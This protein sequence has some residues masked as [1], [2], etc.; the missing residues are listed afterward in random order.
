MKDTGSLGKIYY[1]SEVII[2]QGEV[3]DCMYVIQQGQVEILTEKDGT[4][5]RLAVKGD[6]E[7][8]GEMALVDR[9]VCSATVL[10]LGQAVL[11]TIDKKNFLK[12]VH[13]DPSLALRIVETMSHRIRDL[14]EEIA[15]LKGNI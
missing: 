1:D 4:Q 2:Q 11:L 7:I 6:G 15:R 8:I 3:G 9:E 14:N 5:V 10:A 13:S 12:R